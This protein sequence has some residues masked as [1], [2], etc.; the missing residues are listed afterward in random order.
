M[1]GLLLLVGGCEPAQP[2]FLNR[3]HEECIQGDQWACDLLMSLSKAQ[4]SA[5]KP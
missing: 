3:V 1:L 2:S 4:R 5:Q